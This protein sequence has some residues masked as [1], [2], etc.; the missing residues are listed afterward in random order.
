MILSLIHCARAAGEC[1]LPRHVRMVGSVGVSSGTNP[2]YL[3]APV[4]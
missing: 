4:K 2:Q 1:L 3:K